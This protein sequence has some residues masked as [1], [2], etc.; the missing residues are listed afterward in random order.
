MADTAQKRILVVDDEADVR[1]FISLALEDAGF[2][3]ETA[4][5]GFEGL[6][7]VKQRQPDLITLDL[8]MPK[9]SGAKMY[10]DLNKN[11]AWSSIPVI[12]ITGHAHDELGKADL[13]NLTMSGVGIYLEK[14]VKAAN[15]VAAVRRTLGMEVPESAETKD[16]ATLKRELESLLDGADPATL[17][18]MLK[19]LKDKKK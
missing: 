13:E 17:E 16:P 5:D 7:K 11:K 12:I 15:L 19:S 8:I 9:H 6:E 14:P 2:E 4:S 3:V 18:Q 10:R 1:R